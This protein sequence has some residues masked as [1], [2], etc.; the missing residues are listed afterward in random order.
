M[1]DIISVLPVVLLVLTGLSVADVAVYALIDRTGPTRLVS[2]SSVEVS[3]RLDAPIDPDIYPR[4]RDVSDRDSPEV[5]ARRVELLNRLLMVEVDSP[6]VIVRFK[7]LDGRIWRGE[8]RADP[9]TPEGQYRYVVQR[10]GGVPVGAPEVLAVRVFE[11][12]P[13]LARDYFSPTRRFLGFA[14]WWLTGGCLG[15]VLALVPVYY[16]RESSAERR[17][18]ALGIGQIYRIQPIRRD[19]VALL[20]GLGRRQG[21]RAGQILEIVT[22]DLERTLGEFEVRTVGRDHSRGVSAPSPELHTGCLVIGPDTQEGRP[23]E[24]GV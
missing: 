10:R 18:Q 15:L 17:L 12:E 21:V 16:A 14:P 19:E 7:E 5:Q 23:P 4:R 9:A 13:S 8:L 3:G 11:D 1:R 24:D 22:P 6:H 2:G 20:V